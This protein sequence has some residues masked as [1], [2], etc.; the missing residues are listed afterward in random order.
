MASGDD[1][2]IIMENIVLQNNGRLLLHDFDESHIKGIVVICPGGAYRSLSDRESDPVARA[3]IKAGWG[4]AVLNYSIH[5]AADQPKLERV[6]LMQLAEAVSAMRDRFHD[7]PVVVCGFSAGGHLAASL[8]VHWQELSLPRPD[9]LILS[10][11]VI[12]AGEYANRES[13]ENLTCRKNEDW[14][15]LEHWV[16]SYMPPVYLWHTVTDKDVPVQ[17]SLMLAEQM[18]SHNVTYELHLYPRGVHGLSLATPEVEEAAK[19]RFAD[20]HVASWFNLSVE[21][22]Q[23]LCAEI[24]G[25]KL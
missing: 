11:P 18:S 6:P 20:A 14:F 24:G 8:G 13:F 2:F 7:K 23:Q 9:G 5:T 3:Y 12:S 16:S 21:W 19:R 15:S 22:L 17:N 10:Y 4:A 1:V 25:L